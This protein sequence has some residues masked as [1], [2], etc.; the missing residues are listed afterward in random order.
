MDAAR[1]K[2]W[3][4]IVAIAGLG[5]AILGLPPLLLWYYGYLGGKSASHAIVQL[6][7]PRLFDR[8]HTILEKQS[9][10]QAPPAPGI[11]FTPNSDLTGRVDLTL[12][13]INRV[14]I[15]QSAVAIQGV[16]GEGDT[17]DYFIDHKEPAATTGECWNWYHYTPRDDAQPKEVYVRVEGLWPGQRYCLYTAFRT[18]NGYSKP[19][20]IFC[21]T[22]T[23]KPG[24]GMPSQAPK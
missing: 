13:W 3:Q 24:W 8:A 14:P 2:R 4:W 22:A 12:S 17:T 21:R 1:E 10:L 7:C 6:K 23:W 15:S 9:P 5:I 19:S 20:A 16:Y 11:A 18:N